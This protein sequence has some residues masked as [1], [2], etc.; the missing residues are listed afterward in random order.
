MMKSLQRLAG[1]SQEQSVQQN[2]DVPMEEKTQE[3]FT[4]TTIILS[5]IMLTLL[6]ILYTRAIYRLGAWIDHELLP[7]TAAFIILFP[8][9]VV[10]CVFRRFIKKELVNHAQLVTLY[11]IVSLAAVIMGG[12]GF[13]I[14]L[15]NIMALTSLTSGIDPIFRDAAEA[16]KPVLA[17]MSTLIVPR[18]DAVERGFMLGRSTVPWGQWILPIMIW[19]LYF[20]VIFLV[21]MCI[22]TIFHKHWSKELHFTFPLVQPVVEMLDPATDGKSAIPTFWRNKLVWAGAAIPIFVGIWNNILRQFLLKGIPLIPYSKELDQFGQELGGVWPWLLSSFPPFMLNWD[23]LLIGIGYLLNSDL[24]LSLW[25][26]H[27]FAQRM[28]RALG[29]FLGKQRTGCWEVG[30]MFDQ[31]YAGAIAFAVATLYMS[32]RHLKYVWEQVIKSDGSDAEEGMRYRTAVVGLALGLVFIFL[33]N[34]FLLKVSMLWTVAYFGV[35][36]AVF[37]TFSRARTQLGLPMVRPTSVNFDKLF[38]FST[39]GGKVFGRSAIQGAGFHNSLGY[40][41][42]GSSMAFIFEGQEMADRT[43]M[44]KRSMNKALIF[45]FVAS[46]LI[47]FAV[48][49]PYV[50]KY[51][52]HYVGYHW[53]W[54]SRVGFAQAATLVFGMASPE[55]LPPYNGRFEAGNAVAQ[56]IAVL[57]TI[58]LSYMHSTF[59]WFPLHPLGYVMG[60]ADWPRLFWFGFFIAWAIKSLVFRYGGTALHK[61]VRPFFIGLITGSVIW[62]VTASVISIAVGVPLLTRLW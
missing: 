23:P 18:G 20:T 31:Y 17:Q 36:L 30:F 2:A 53:Q 5:L 51:G 32:R 43:K 61:K 33:F 10:N 16:L 28:P 37:L 50:Y 14:I 42:V 58:F 47:A 40:G 54:H 22:A 45:A 46:L 26:F 25:F 34:T 24:S 12:G 4:L 27:I 60:V 55:G 29:Y 57:F 59:A 15:G 3:G 13:W 21:F 1:V 6:A 11:S 48:G 39:F 62:W 7:S 49:L 8:L 56:A 35:G 52:F 9:I 41:T 19:T 38:L 44:P